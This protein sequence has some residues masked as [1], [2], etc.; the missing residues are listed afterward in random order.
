MFSKGRVCVKS[1]IFLF[2]M[3][4]LKKMIELFIIVMY[5]NYCKVI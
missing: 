1:Y 2:K 5:N 3:K 4:M